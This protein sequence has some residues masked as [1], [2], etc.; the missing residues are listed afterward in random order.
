MSEAGRQRVA[1]PA[2]CL[3][4]LELA[5]KGISVR[6]IAEEVF[7]D[8]RF[9]GRVERILRTSTQPDPS[10]R[11]TAPPDSTMSVETVPTVRAAL[12][13]YLGRIERGELQPSISEM[14]KL[15][16]LERRLQTF[17][18]LE[19]LNELTLRGDPLPTGD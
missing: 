16:D 5:T 11:D 1:T 10:E 9:R 13:R 12:R 14:V 3:Q 7:G 15:L 2:E 19:Q 18:T 17:E 8:A 6:R 4:V